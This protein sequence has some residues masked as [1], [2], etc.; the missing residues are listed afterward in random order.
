MDIRIAK[1]TTPTAPSLDLT[2]CEKD[3]PD[4]QAMSRDQIRRVFEQAYSR[5]TLAERRVIALRGLGWSYAEIAKDL[6]LA[7]TSVGALA[8]RGRKKLKAA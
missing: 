1:R 4:L 5:L 2:L 3:R 7:Q 6:A 8:S